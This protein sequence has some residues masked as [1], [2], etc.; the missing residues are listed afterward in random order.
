MSITGIHACYRLLSPFVVNSALL[1]KGGGTGPA[2]P[3][4]ARPLSMK[5][6]IFSGRPKKLASETIV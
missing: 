6:L 2:G 3:V 5:I 1:P 4:L